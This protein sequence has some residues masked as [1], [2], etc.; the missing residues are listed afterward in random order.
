MRLLCPVAGCRLQLSWLV[1]LAALGAGS[2]SFRPIAFSVRLFVTVSRLSIRLKVC[3][4]G[5]PCAPGRLAAHL[6]RFQCFSHSPML[7]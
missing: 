3:V 5:A 2:P 7:S 1:S 4:D 6:P